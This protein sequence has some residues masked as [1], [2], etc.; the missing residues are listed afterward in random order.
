MKILIKLFIGLFFLFVASAAIGAD[1]GASQKVDGLADVGAVMTRATRIPAQDMNDLDKLGFVD[2][3]DIFGLLEAGD[4]PDLSA[5]Y[6]AVGDRG[7]AND[8]LVEMDDT[9]CVDNEYA[10]MTANGIECRS[11]AEVLSDIGAEVD[12]VDEAGLYSVL[13]DVTQFYEPNDNITVGTVSAGAGGFTVDAD[14]DVVAKSITVAANS[15]PGWA[16]EDSDTSA[17]GTFTLSIDAATVGQD[18]QIIFKVDD[19]SGEDTTYLTIDGVAEQHTF[20]KPLSVTGAITA[21][22]AIQ[23]LVNVTMDTAATVD[24]SDS[25][26]ADGEWRVNNDDDV[27]QYTLPPAV[28]GL[29]VCFYDHSAN[30]QIISLDPD[31]GT[32]QIY[33]NGAGIGAGDEL[34]SPGDRGDFVCLMALDG[35]T[36]VTLGMSGTWVDGGAT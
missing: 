20:A 7:I 19:S 32:D 22:G 9:D 28:A 23:G 3:V 13:S 27:I 6:E 18:S 14:G 36:W 12:L 17:T 10:K 29:T 2:A 4:I 15:S 8:N 24:L 35:D 25:T 31:D 11:Y 16:G 33:L 21:T 30:G 1:Y 34:D 26:G 5:S